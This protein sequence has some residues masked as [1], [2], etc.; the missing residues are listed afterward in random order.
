MPAK[1][2]QFHA[3]FS[4]ETQRQVGARASWDRT[5]ECVL[6]VVFYSSSGLVARREGAFGRWRWRGVSIVNT[7]QNLENCG[8]GHLRRKRSNHES[9]SVHPG[10]ENHNIL[11]EQKCLG[12][13]NGPDT[14][15]QVEALGERC[16]TSP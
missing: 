11:A 2:G 5:D 13:E 6:H 4:Q 9:T 1:R 8:L 7:H 14:C 15:H 12:H 10:Q 3:W 16:G